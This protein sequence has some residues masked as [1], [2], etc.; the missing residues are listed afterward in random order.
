MSEHEDPQV[1]ISSVPRFQRPHL[2]EDEKNT[3]R[4][5]AV[6]SSLGVAGAASIVGVAYLRSPEP[7]HEVADFM[8]NNPTQKF[9]ALF[10]AGGAAAI[11]YAGIRDLPEGP[12]ATIKDARR[13]RARKLGVPGTLV[14]LAMLFTPLFD[15]SDAKPSTPSD[16]SAQVTTTVPERSPIETTTTVRSNPI[17][18]VRLELPDIFACNDPDEGAPLMFTAGDNLRK[19]VR[20]A[21]TA[22]SATGYSERQLDII[23]KEEVDTT[24]DDIAVA[25]LQTGTRIDV[26]CPDGK[27]ST[28]GVPNAA[29]GVYKDL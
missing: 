19:F 12:E 3:V 24:P 25:G 9:G 4:N 2:T 26:D 1:K 18:N 7:V 28:P 5:V 21:G 10:L 11:K 13:N 6:V 29:P 20:L 8:F 27:S 22:Y 16:R 14:G 15:A 23:F 17:P